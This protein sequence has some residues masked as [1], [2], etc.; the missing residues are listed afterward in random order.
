MTYY[1]DLSCN[2]ESYT[3]IPQYVEDYGPQCVL[4]SQIKSVTFV[5]DGFLSRRVA[6]WSMVIVAGFYSLIPYLSRRTPEAEDHCKHTT[7]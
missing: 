7:S 6:L 3:L 1:Y 2:S 4:T 5:C